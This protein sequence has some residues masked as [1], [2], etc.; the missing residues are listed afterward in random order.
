MVSS[1]LSRAKLRLLLILFAACA[2]LAGPL[3]QQARGALTA[4]EIRIADHAGFVRV[5]VDFSGG[6]VLTGEVVATDP[7]PFPDGV[8]RLPLERRGVRTQAA[9][10]EAHGVRVRIGQGSRRI[11]IHLGADP[12]RF[13]YVRYFALRDPHR[14]VLDL[15]KSAPPT[16]AAELFSG[17]RGCLTLRSFS[18]GTRTVRAAGR[19]RDLFEH[20]LAVRLRGS[21]GR[22]IRERGETAADG[23][24]R[25]RFRY[26]ERRR[27]S[28]T[29]EA[30]A[31][32]AKDGTLECIVQARVTL[33]G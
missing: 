12:R 26:P 7:D 19:E 25:T 11:V 22:V 1:S 31:L 14:L 6:R 17:A 10:R 9:A 2:A 5:V 20:S 29:L 32:S 4:D 27:Q 8:A 15:Y 21:G 28:G 23:R 33:G 24:W 13:K 30:V 3:A 18:V 16:A